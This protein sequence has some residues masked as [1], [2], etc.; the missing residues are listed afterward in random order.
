[1]AKGLDIEIRPLLPED[2]EVLAKI[3]HS[4][5]T[6]FVWQMAMDRDEGNISIKFKEIRLPRSMRVDYPWPDTRILGDWK[7]RDGVMV[8]LVDEIP[9]GYASVTLDASEELASVTDLVVTRRLRRRGIGTALLHAVSIGLAKEGVRQVML[10]MQSKNHPA[11][12]LADQMGYEFCGYS[13]Q[14]YPNLDIALFFS[15]RI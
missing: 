3:D 8:A 6:D 4:Y 11:I 1:M 7:S 14:Y 9:V 10:E 5:H 15:K 12:G 13:D 2:L